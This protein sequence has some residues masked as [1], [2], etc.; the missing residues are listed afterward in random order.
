MPSYNVS[1]HNYDAM[2]AVGNVLEDMVRLFSGKLRVFA[3]NKLPFYIDYEQTVN[4][5][6][7]EWR[8]DKPSSAPF[9][10]VPGFSNVVMKRL[11]EANTKCHQD[12]K[13]SAK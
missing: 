8:A 5:R 4:K 10:L 2:H 13:D 11:N 1:D 7:L 6:F 9:S 3:S 12:W